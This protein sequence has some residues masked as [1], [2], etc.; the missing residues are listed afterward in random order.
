M[1]FGAGRLQLGDHNS[2]LPLPRSFLIQSHTHCGREPNPSC[3]STAQTSMNAA[4]IPGTLSS[5]LQIFSQSL[6]LQRRYELEAYRTQSNDSEPITASIASLSKAA[7][8]VKLACR[9]LGFLI[10]DSL[11]P[12]AAACPSPLGRV[13]YQ[14]VEVQYSLSPVV[15]AA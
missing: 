1:T 6:L 2:T 4:F 13:R 9:N 7:A 8:Q 12:T 10:R 15:V 5:F 11:L 14:R 3:I